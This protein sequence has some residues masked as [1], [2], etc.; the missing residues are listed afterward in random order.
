MGRT[1]THLFIQAALLGYIP[2]N[3]NC[4]VA[5]A[6]CIENGR[7][8]IFD[9]VFASIARDKQAPVCKAGHLAIQERKT[10]RVFERGPHLLIKNDHHLQ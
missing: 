2:E 10:D 1:V 6:L 8:G 5:Y 7:R 9:S 3:K 4:T